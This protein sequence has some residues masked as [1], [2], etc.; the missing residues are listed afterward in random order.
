MFLIVIDSH[1][2]WLE[3]FQ[4]STTTSQ[5][6]IQRLRTVF[7]QFGLPETVV[8]DNGPNFTSSEFKEF[9]HRN[10]IAHVTS[11]TFIRHQTASLIFIGKECYN[12][13]LKLKSS[14]NLRRVISVAAPSHDNV[15]TSEDKQI[16]LLNPF[17]KAQ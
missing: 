5:V 15:Q 4:M 6:V 11:S 9:L 13:L 10:G 7:A 1:S 12:S 16:V 2:K 3:V 8:T 17:M 14:F